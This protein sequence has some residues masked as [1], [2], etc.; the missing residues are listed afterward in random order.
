MS[1]ILSFLLLAA[2]TPDPADT[3]SGV[4]PQ[5]VDFP[6]GCDPL[7]PEYCG[8][9][10][11]SD[12]WLAADATTATGFRLAIPQEAIPDPPAQTPFDTA[13][14]ERL[15][16]FTAAP[17]LLALFPVPPDL[18]GIAGQ[19]DIGRSLQDDSPTVV[20]DLDTGERV[21]HWVELD[22][23]AADDAERTL[24]LRLAERLTEGH[25]YGV[26]LRGLVD[27]AA[28]PIEPSEAF[29]LLRDGTI[30]DDAA[31]E[32][33]RASYET[34]FDT[35][36][37]AGV[38]R[39]E[40]TLAWWFQVASAESIHG[41]LLAMRADALDRLGAEG[42]GCTIASAEDGYGGDG[43][44]YRR[45]TGTYTVPWYLDSA[46]A[47]SRI[48]RG[49]D[50]LPA[51]Q[52][53]QEVGFS[54]ILPQSLASA[55]TPGPLVTFGHGLMGDADDYMTWG[56]IRDIAQRGAAVLV[57]TDWA[58][59]CT[60]DATAVAQAIIDPSLF[61][62]VAE[63]LQQGMINQIALTRTFSGVCA[64]LPEV[65][66]D[67]V[68]MID[69]ERRYFVGVSQGGILGATLTAVSPDIDRAALLVNGAVFPFMIE[70]SI[71]FVPYLPLWESA[72][73]HRLD[74]VFLLALSEE[75][76]EHAEGSGYLASLGEGLADIGPK[77]VLSLAAS[78]DAEVP[79]LST[80]WAMRTAGM[81]VIRGSARE[82]WGLEVVDAPWDGS[83]GF[84]LDFGDDPVPT[85]NEAPPDNDG[86]H[87]YVPTSDLALQVMLHFFETGEVTMPCDGTCDPD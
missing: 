78:N 25:R 28:T 85:G 41:D 69:P 48:V 39:G 52:G 24:Y 16:G 57:A 22:V 47:P 37:Q 72:Y 12:A 42:L 8:Y 4:P 19:D 50:G 71:D 77:R 58:G 32:A 26:A 45:V 15:D 18:T 33:R 76:W 56:T 20:L 11:P 84:T 83:G 3:D 51:Y 87:W 29:V 66:A 60:D 40:L 61:V 54:L 49:A 80:D 65:Q 73:T 6:E 81:P 21:A 59:M 75:L 46:E 17:Q 34:L 23:K 74:Q 53:T 13:P 36:E 5:H 2:C 1:T 38:D 27:S 14:Y 10:Y 43:I 35:L 30:T 82:P 67:G 64:D 62:T 79:N 55:G 86:G 68:S 70:R 44:T 63:R 31:L 9:P 7:V